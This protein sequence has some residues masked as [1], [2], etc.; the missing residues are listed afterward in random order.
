MKTYLIMGA[1]ALFAMGCASEPKLLRHYKELDASGKP[2]DS[3]QL[4]VFLANPK[5]TEDS[6]L[7]FGLAERAQAELIHV[8]AA[9]VTEKGAPSDLMALLNK[10]T[11]S[12]PKE[13]SWAD[14]TSM[15]K[16]L[17]F[18]VLGDLGKPAD[19]IDKLEFLLT[20]VP[21]PSKPGIAPSTPEATFSSWDRFDSKY[22]DF[23]I[24]SATFTQANKVSAGT[25]RTATANLPASAGSVVKVFDLGYESDKTLEESADYALRRLSVGGA[26]TPTTARLVQE[27]GPNINL[28]GSSS[29]VI[30]F[31]LRTSGDPAPAYIFTLMRNEKAVSPSQ[32]GVERCLS[33]YPRTSKELL[34]EISGTA[35]L[36][37]VNSGDG[38]VS[39]GDDNIQIR[40]VQL[41][42]TTVVLATPSELAVQ[43]FGLVQCA[44]GSAL[45]DCQRLHIENND[46]GTPNAEQILLPSISEAASLRAW[47]VEQ[48]KSKAVPSIGGLAIGMAP[49]VSSPATTAKQ[50]HGVKAST[51]TQLRVVRLGGNE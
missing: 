25:T 8:L 32:A 40:P 51:A 21:L 3:L 7:V 24:G 4:S 42:K 38:T 12:A 9:K 22:V 28:L 11:A 20:L 41:S 31:K 27:G 45:E 49:L 23:K 47:L 5:D 18:T 29:A 50:L 43:H 46:T 10:P 34:V 1:T 35:L 39:E 30:S 37:E 26:L 15:S 19:R 13:C 48:S 6:P 44:T 14:K 17:I 16:R 2:P 33:M 36:R